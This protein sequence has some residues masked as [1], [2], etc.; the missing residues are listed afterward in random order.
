MHKC[1]VASGLGIFIVG[2]IVGYAVT[3]RAPVIAAT[4]TAVVSP[5]ALMLKAK[6]LPVETVDAS[7]SAV[8]SDYSWRHWPSV[9]DF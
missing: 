6:D 7:D 1:A 8:S 9:T 5:F 2:A 3:G 4:K